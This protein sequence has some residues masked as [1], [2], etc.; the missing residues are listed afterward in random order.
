MIKVR[1]MH[2]HINAVEYVPLFAA[3][4]LHAGSM[5]D[6]QCVSSVAHYGQLEGFCLP[7]RARCSTATSACM[8][9]CVRGLRSRTRAGPALD[10]AALIVVASTMVSTV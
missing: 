9:V 4:T 8:Y 3:Q 10:T 7:D 2:P 1:V 6:G 5:A